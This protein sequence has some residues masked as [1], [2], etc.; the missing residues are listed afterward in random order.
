MEARAHPHDTRV[1]DVEFGRYVKRL[2]RARGLTQEQLAERSGLSS[3]T[4]RRL[5]HGAFSPSLETLTKLCGGMSLRLSTLFTAFELSERDDAR[6]IV[7]LL[8]S[9]RPDQYRLAHRVLRTLFDE[10]DRQAPP[11]EPVD[12]RD[13]DPPNEGELIGDDPHGDEPE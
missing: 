12:L 9:R 8:A 11:A 5:E 6:E 7:D 10:L 13:D 4:I 3:D 1:V 2:R